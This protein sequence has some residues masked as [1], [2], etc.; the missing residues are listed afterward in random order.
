MAASRPP[1][2]AVAPPTAAQLEGATRLYRVFAQVGPDTPRES[3]D[4]FRA[5]ASD[6]GFGIQRGVEQV[7]FHVVRAQVR[8]NGQ[9]PDGADVAADARRLAAWMEVKLGRKVEVKDIG[10]SFPNMPTTNLEL[11]LPGPEGIAQPARGPRLKPSE[12]PAIMT[13][14]R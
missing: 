10:K 13:P 3:V 12:R 1:A 7:R 9:G 11:W 6:A 4:P 14:E 8:Y 5:E 2:D